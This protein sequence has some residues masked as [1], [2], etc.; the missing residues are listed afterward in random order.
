MILV[1]ALYTIIDSFTSASNTVMSYID[2]IYNESKT[3]L[4][5]SMAWIYFVIIMLIIA[6][7]MGIFSAY[8]F[9]QKRDA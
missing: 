2:G 9:Y 8:V 1:I 4:A 3:V 6:A 5:T 7:F